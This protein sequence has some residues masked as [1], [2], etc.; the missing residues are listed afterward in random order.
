[1]VAILSE[2]ND[3]VEPHWFRRTIERLL[4]SLPDGYC[5][6]LASIVLT[7]AVVATARK[8][9]RKSRANRRGIPLGRYHRAWNGQ[10]A[11]VELVVDEIVKQLP[12]PF[13]RVQI[14]RD[15]VVGRVLF[16]EIGHHLD[17]TVGSVGRTGERGAEAWEARLS[18]IHLRRRY[19][20][21]RPLSPVLAVFGRM[22]R[23]LSRREARD[24]KAG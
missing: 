7:E 19:G 20:Y 9:A 3:Y 11:W 18:R 10:P 14:T 21:L 17:A 2:C 23:N 22:A 1:M 24:G 6:G 8:G 5:Q 12:K 4:S 13:D 16:H 15:F